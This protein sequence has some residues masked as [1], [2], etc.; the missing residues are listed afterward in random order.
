MKDTGEVRH[1]MGGSK[2]DNNKKTCIQIKEEC[3]ACERKV[4]ASPV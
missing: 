1:L 4:N 2:R 3:P